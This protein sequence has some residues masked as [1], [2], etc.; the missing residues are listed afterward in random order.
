MGVSL[1][2]SEPY[3]TAFDRDGR[4]LAGIDRRG[5][6]TTT[7]R[8]PSRTLIEL[9]GSEA[10]QAI[11]DAFAIAFDIPT[12]ILDH[13][14]YNVNEITHRVAFCEDF[15]RTSSAG[16]NCLSCDRSGIRLSSQTRRPTIFKCWNELHDCTV[17][18]VSSRGELFGYFLSGQVL[19]EEGLD[20]DAL[21]AVAR[22]HDIDE[23]AYID[24]AAELRVIP[25]A[26]YARSI[27]CIGV[28]ARMIADQASSALRH[29]ELLDSLLIAQGQTQRLAAEFDEVAAISSQIAGSEDTVAALHRLADAIERV[30]PHDSMVIFKRDSTDRLHPVMVRDPFA[31]ALEQWEPRLGIGLVG[32]VATTGEILH[33]DDVRADPRFEPIPGVPVEPE[34]LLVAPLQLGGDII[35]AVQLSRFQKQ[36][37]TEHDRDL[38]KIVASYTAVALGTASL[39][40][41]AVHYADVVRARRGVRERFASGMSDTALVEEFTREALQVFACERAALRIHQR[42]DIQALDCLQMTLREQRR[43]ERQ[44][45]EAVAR[46][47]SSAQ[48]VAVA[49]GPANALIV[50]FEVNGQSV[51]HLILIRQH[52]FP[53]LEQQLALSFAEH[54]GVVIESAVAQRRLRSLGART[55]RLAEIA[56]A[57]ARARYRD[58]IAEAITRAH[59]LVDGR[60]TILALGDEML[61]GFR[62][63]GSG[64]R[65]REREIRTAGRP[66]LRLPEVRGDN[67]EF[68]DLFDAWGATFAGTVTGE[69]GNG[70]VIAVP[71]LQR[72][73]LVGAIIV[74]EP[75]EFDR[76]GRSLLQA[77]AR[78][79]EVGLRDAAPSPPARVGLEDQLVRMHECSQRLLSINDPA[80]LARAI[81]EEFVVLT[82]AE[83]ALLARAR[84][85]GEVETLAVAGSARLAKRRLLRFI[86]ELG[87]PN[88]GPGEDEVYGV[89]ELRSGGRLLLVGPRPL[90]EGLNPRVRAGFLGY[91]G[92]ALERAWEFLD[93]AERI[94]TL[95]CEQGRLVES[96]SRLAVIVD[97]NSLLTEA[98][99]S[100]AWFANTTELLARLFGCEIAI[101]GVDGLRIAA[102][103]EDS[104]L[105]SPERQDL[106]GLPRVDQSLEV[107]GHGR[108]VATPILA[109]GEDLGWLVRPDTGNGI[110]PAVR[111]SAAANAAITLLRLR[112]AEETEARLRGDFLDSLLRNTVPG[113]ELIR[114]GS[115]LG[116][117]LTQPWR[118]V[119]AVLLD[120]DASDVG[121]LVMRW[122]ASRRQK[123]LIA[124]RANEL[125]IVGPAEGAWPEDL[126][127]E[128]LR[129]R[130]ISLGVGPS[131]LDDGF[132]GSYIAARQAAEAMVRLGRRGVLRMD[133]DCLEQLLL[134]SANPDRLAGFRRRVLEPL[135]TY[136]RDHGSSLRQTLE[137]ACSNGWNV[138]ATARA[139]HVHHSTLR[140]RLERISQLTG[141]DLKDQDGRLSLQLAL[142]V[143]RLA[144]H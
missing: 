50:P 67:P 71:V 121:R 81:V 51:G 104:V 54:A 144:P 94:R 90:D 27:E 53:E 14:G 89:F 109:D 7:T 46:A 60:L 84:S 119:V 12:V 106:I 36:T 58:E 70:R 20:V 77:V 120:S 82:G 6:E 125:V 61:G 139:A 111:T 39:R 11:Q 91:A 140:Y 143:D 124:V 74:V 136:D 49:D 134:R 40:A 23:D 135:D 116:Y 105:L 131:T 9:I 17:P 10:L 38:L 83:G 96:S 123:L 100:R 117:D 1:R 62:V 30:I 25:L 41:E 57:V 28:L 127:E 22:E 110:D 48:P 44:H 59:E 15:T 68:D 108:L 33:L 5:S 35:G 78:L 87:V 88:P 103:N 63:V 19:G 72:Q 112:A 138:L 55:R 37:F 18:I 114:Q 80:Q 118:A 76:D 69:T 95:E 93:L 34:A 107:P 43:F 16:S 4:D 45:A 141:V 75:S 8:I 130:N 64:E 66:E 128:F 42:S 122:G 29:R 24:A 21:R 132:S 47:C 129:V 85:G 101:Y 73:N 99:L 98:A 133:E 113:D 86:S 32:S 79:V 142:L 26:T 2:P 3:V 137:L 115:S 97:T 126:H 31:S 13:E 52:Q 56:G 102:S 92:M 65:G